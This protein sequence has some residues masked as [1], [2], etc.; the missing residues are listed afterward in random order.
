M[1]PKSQPR[2]SREQFSDPEY[3]AIEAAR[4]SLSHAAAVAEVA[5]LTEQYRQFWQPRAAGL[6]EL[7]AILQTLRAKRIS[8]VLTGAHGF[9]AWTGR[10]RSTHDVDILVSAGRDY[11]RAVNA[12]R[13]LHPQLEARQVSGETGFF[14]SGET[15]SL[16]DVIHPHRADLEETLRTA[17]WVEEG[18]PHYRVPTLECALANKYGAMLD[19]TRNFCTRVQDVVDFYIMVKLASDPGRRPIDV[20]KLRELGRKV[21]PG[22]GTRIVRLMEEVHADKV[23]NLNSPGEP[24]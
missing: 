24:G 12:L 9:A 16:L 23:P 21:A 8:F 7:T 4:R 20:G 6:I 17:I 10:P 1:A 14:L 19:P 22:G 5:F 2:G 15:H 13:A 3:E 18:E 11:A